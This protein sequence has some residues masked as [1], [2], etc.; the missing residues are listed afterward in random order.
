MSAPAPAP[1]SLMP[2]RIAWLA[3]S[4]WILY[5]LANTIYAAVV[6]YVFAPYVKTTFGNDSMVGIATTVS[7][8][9]S[10]LM[11]PVM[12]SLCDRTGQ[13]R[14]YLGV[15]T[16]A[17]VGAM[18]GMAAFASSAVVLIAMYAVANI[19]Y[20]NA[21]T[22]YNALLPSVAPPERTGL[23]SGLGVGIGYFGTIVT[24]AVA[25]GLA[26]Y[27][28]GYRGV[29]AVS[30]ALFLIL[31]VPC[32]VFV[33]EL[34]VTERQAS[35]WSLAREQWTSIGKTL[36]EIRQDRTLLLFFVGS[37][38]LIDVLNTAILFFGSLTEGLF[39]HLADEGRLTLIVNFSNV[40]NFAK[41]LG[42]VLCFLAFVFGSLIGWLGDRYHPLRCLRASGWCL[43]LAFFGAM[44]SGGR[45]PWLYAL[46]M[47]VLGAIGL[48][49]IW[50]AGRQLLIVLAPAD[51][52]GEYSGL[53]GITNK[54]SVIGSTTFALVADWSRTN[55]GESLGV[56]PAIALALSQRDALAC[57]MV[58][59]VLG[60][61]LL[62]GI[63]VED[64]QARSAK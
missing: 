45:S 7:M 5:D 26:A 1:A 56:T 61:V 11:V 28:F 35:S 48:A 41:V 20:Q 62:Y 21:L 17:C 51:Q 14:L 33:R 16:L 40:G 25:L 8:I 64:V 4:S 47:C 3:A 44:L 31:S 22:F 29:T 57:Q 2:T 18:F 60:V 34:R 39:Q 9:A 58:Q 52:V 19:A 46:S 24:I 59:L 13:A 27:G 53:Y 12:A 49:G 38:F 30:A 10:G 6:T 43:L 15:F 55:V 50:T 37:F 63:R 36:R 42:L 23:I 54:L 32:L